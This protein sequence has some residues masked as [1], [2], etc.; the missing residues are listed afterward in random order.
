MNPPILPDI[1]IFLHS[2]SIP[3]KRNDLPPNLHTNIYKTAIY[4]KSS[5]EVYIHKLYYGNVGELC[6]SSANSKRT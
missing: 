3:T 2:I 6:A 4:K 5:T 1:E